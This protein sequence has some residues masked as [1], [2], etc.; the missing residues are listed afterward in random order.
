MAYKTMIGEI[1]CPKCRQVFEEGSRRFCPTDGARLV[2]E[3]LDQDDR[4]G[5]I[6]ADLLQRS[7]A[8]GN[9]DEHLDD[10]P[11]FTLIEDEPDLLGVDLFATGDEPRSVEEVAGRTASRKVNPSEIPAG[12]VDLS[13]KERKVAAFGEF[14]REDPERFISKTVKGRYVI[15]QYLGG[16]ET[17]FA[18][19]ADDQI[20]DRKVLVRILPAGETDDVV[21]GILAEERVSLSHFSHP[22]IAR[23]IDSGAFTNGIQF[24]ISEYS[25]ALTVRDILDIHGALELGRAARVLKQAAHALSGAH[26]AGIIHR[27][28]RPENVVLI[29][30]GD[31][32]S[33][34]LVNF[35]ASTGTN[36]EQCRL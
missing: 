29:N 12:H 11:T 30:E 1:Y 28:L 14:N 35:G 17:G 27:D 6:F 9:M 25:D 18:Y 16:D 26:Q 15:S 19:I 34:K 13:D 32:E 5:G 20:G 2:S 7:A 36:R 4:S 31:N 24:L 22:N 23:L 8:V 21:S 33:V 10:S 3:D